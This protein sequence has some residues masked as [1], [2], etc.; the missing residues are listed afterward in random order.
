MGGV[1]VWWGERV[2]RG[3][4][5]ATDWGVVGGDGVASNLGEK[6]QGMIND[7]QT[8]AG[9]SIKCAKRSLGSRQYPPPPPP[10][11]LLLSSLAVSLF[12]H[13]GTNYQL[14]FLFFFSSLSLFPYT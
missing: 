10:P 14:F 2:G 5:A 1:R 13:C 4:G 12:S 8:A 6:N 7:S 3:R 11:F 9:R